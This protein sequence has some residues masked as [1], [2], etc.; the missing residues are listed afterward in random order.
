MIHKSPFTHTHNR[1]AID[2]DNKVKPWLQGN[3]LVCV[4]QH[5]EAICAT[6]TR[7]LL[8]LWSSIQSWYKTIESAEHCG[9]DS[10]WC[11]FS[12]WCCVVG[13]DDRLSVLVLVCDGHSACALVRGWGYSSWIATT[14]VMSVEVRPESCSTW[15]VLHDQE[16]YSWVNLTVLTGSRNVVALV[17]KR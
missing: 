6:D 4:S 8:V 9:H 11:S 13:V 17:Q 7:L 5:L 10:W 1:P 2:T 3:L 16:L 14:S 15:R 12:C